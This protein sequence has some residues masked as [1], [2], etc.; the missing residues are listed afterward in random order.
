MRLIE[1]DSICCPPPLFHCFGLVL[2]LLACI[3][4]GATLVLPSETFDPGAV[5]QAVVTEKCTGL[6]GVP[7]MFIAELDYM[8]QHKTLG[9]IVLRTGVVAGSPVSPSLMARLQQTFGLPDLTITYGCFP[10]RCLSLS[11]KT[12]ANDVRL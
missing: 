1:Q 11:R 4:T 12:R 6:H 10:F 2:G 7:T 5:L 8:R 3:T 9:K